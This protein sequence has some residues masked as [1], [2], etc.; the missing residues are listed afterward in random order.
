MLSAVVTA[1]GIETCN[2]FLLDIGT[3]TSAGGPLPRPHR[4]DQP[5]GPH[6]NGS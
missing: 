3:I 6:R 5:F 2:T 1:G 4:T